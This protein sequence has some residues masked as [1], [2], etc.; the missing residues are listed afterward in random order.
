MDID[1]AGYIVRYYNH[2]MTVQERRAHRHLIGTAKLTHGRTD[3]AAQAEAGSRSHPVRE[4]LSDD[5]DVLEL[6]SEGI[7]AFVARTAQRILD[8][9]ANKVFFNHCPKCGA[10][11]KTPKA[12]QCRFCY[13]D[14]H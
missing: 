13:R 14:W 3:A 11:A 12:R 10:L 5:P 2:L 7:D 6:A 1:K 8:E 9:H 4:L